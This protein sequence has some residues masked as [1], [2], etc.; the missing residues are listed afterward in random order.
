MSTLRP[1]GTG[2]SGSTTASRLRRER[3]VTLRRW[4][5]RVLEGVT[6]PVLSAGDGGNSEATSSA[7]GERVTGSGRTASARADALVGGEEVGVTI[8]ATGADGVVISIAGDE[9]GSELSS[10]GDDGEDITTAGG[11]TSAEWLSDAEE[12]C[13]SEEASEKDSL[14]TGLFFAGEAWAG[15]LLSDAVVVDASIAA[16]GFSGA[17]VFCD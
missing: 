13:A 14:A 7:N 16:A 15:L 9:T 17:D 1:S 6:V 12:S 10:G 5:R 8:L 2:D 4:I 3:G 11:A